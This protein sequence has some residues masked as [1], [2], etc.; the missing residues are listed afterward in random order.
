M[1]KR[2]RKTQGGTRPDSIEKRRM[3][4]LKKYRDDAKKI[5]EKNKAENEFG[6]VK[7]KSIGHNIDDIDVDDYNY[8][9]GPYGFPENVRKTSGNYGFQVEEKNSSGIRKKRAA[10]EEEAKRKEKQIIRRGLM[11]IDKAG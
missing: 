8:S 7:T 9:I 4:L 10:E 11:K 3:S 2:R 1:T 5:M 6:F